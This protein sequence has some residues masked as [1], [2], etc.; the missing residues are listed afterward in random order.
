MKSNF[1]KL[2]LPAFA[3][4]L[5]VGL[6]FATEDTPVFRT[7]YYHIPNDDWYSTTVGEECQ[8]QGGNPCMF[9][10]Y[11]LYAGPSYGSGALKKIPSSIF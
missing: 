9:E 7:A 1:L 11:Q 3:I 8:V 2:V 10:E 6:A 4:L 5:A